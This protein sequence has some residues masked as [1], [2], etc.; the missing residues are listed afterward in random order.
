MKVYRFVATILLAVVLCAGETAGGEKKATGPT[1]QAEL[2]GTWSVVSMEDDGR[3]VSSSRANTLRF[4]FS[5]KK[6]TM[7]ILEQVIAETEY[8]ADG[9]KQPATIDLTYE[10]EPTPGIYQLKG[11][12]LK[13]C[14]GRSAE[15]RSS[16]FESEEGSPSRVL[17]VLKRGDL[18]PVG[19]PFF[20]MNADGTGL[21]K[22]ADLPKDM[23]TGSPDWSRDGNKIAFDGWRLARGESGN[24]AHI[25]VV[26][27]DG[28]G[29][30]DLGAGAM[31]SW[32]PDGKRLV[33]CKYGSGIWV[34]NADGSGEKHIG[35]EGWGCDW[36]PTSDQIVTTVYGPANV[37]I[38]DVD[39]GDWRSLLE[40]QQYRS[41]Y[42]NLCWSPDGKSICFKGMR[43][44]G[45]QEVAIV[46]AK[47]D[48][49]GFKVLLST[50]DDPFDSIN[51]I[52]AWEGNAEQILIPLRSKGSKFWQMYLLD[53]KGKLPPERL[54]G[55]KDE[56][57][58]AEMAW[59]PDGKQVVFN[60]E[61]PK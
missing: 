55:Q 7:R 20:L 15:E 30:Q 1:P 58:Y 25:C 27:A 34:M 4:Q 35:D 38:I 45:T 33:F 57:H 37:C 26:N 42:W 54:P 31:P 22:L 32:S 29:F 50:K 2:G 21:R 9:T 52:V 12:D 51:P 17:I 59:S 19:R 61:E 13:I 43:T 41:I 16:K 14:L 47:G 10:G 53:P 11:D 44:D 8:T 36:S 24:R 56:G 18:G 5:A 28:T 60:I 48:A 46:N 3:K 23:M 6:L 49:H 40:T 39:T